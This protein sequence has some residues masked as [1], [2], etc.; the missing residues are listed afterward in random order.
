MK[1]FSKLLIVAMLS[2]VSASAF[3]AKNSVYMDQIGSNTTIDVTQTGSG[4]QMGTEATP[5]SFNG[6]S[7]DITITQIGSGN[8]GM[9][10]INGIGATVV[11]NVTGSL[12]TQN[13]T[14]GTDSGS[15]C[16]DTSIT[17]S[18]TGS[19]NT[20]TINAQANS[21]ITNST[22]GDYNTTNINSK[23][24]NLLGAF[25]N[26]T[27]DGNSN[28]IT[29]SQDGAA[30]LNGFSTSISVTGA[31]NT[32]G[33]TQSGTVDSTVQINSTGSNNNINV[34]SGN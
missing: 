12:N 8:F 7:Q 18:I 14:C 28:D 24:T 21:T 31:S 16:S 20:E 29:V 5:S 1:Q 15:T 23:T 26:L 10:T 25:V 6:N 17:T 4:N 33:V 32:I 19:N 30:G 27:T 9:F 11:S 34:T 3:A 13:M 22:T 2:T